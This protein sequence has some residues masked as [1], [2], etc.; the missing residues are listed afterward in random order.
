[1][2]NGSTPASP[3]EREPEKEGKEERS[4]TEYGEKLPDLDPMKDL[5]LP[6]NYQ[7]VVRRFERLQGDRAMEL[8][9]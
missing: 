3:E 6:E 5:N 1:M 9:N 8:L 2:D 7:E 4:Y